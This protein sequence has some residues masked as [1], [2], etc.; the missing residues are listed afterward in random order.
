[1]ERTKCTCAH[2][3]GAVGLPAGNACLSVQDKLLEAPFLPSTQ[4]LCKPFRQMNGEETNRLLDLSK[5]QHSEQH[6]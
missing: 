3:R 6:I 2:L 1:M 5:R 4:S